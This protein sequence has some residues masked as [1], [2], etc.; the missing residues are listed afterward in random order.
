[1]VAMVTTVATVT[2]VVM[3]TCEVFALVGVA[4]AHH[5]LL[6]EH[7]SYDVLH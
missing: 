7:L 1:M 6:M 5:I 2:M 4:G 3:V